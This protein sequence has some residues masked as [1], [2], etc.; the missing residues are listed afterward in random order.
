M[1]LVPTIPV[2]VS[3]TSAF[4]RTAREIMSAAEIEALIDRLAR[5]PKAGDII[6]GTGGVR[7]FRW[8]RPG[9]GKRG[10]V[11]VI[12]YYHDDTMPL[13]LL[14]AYAK[15]AVADI[16]A[17]QKRRIS[18]LVNDYARAQKERRSRR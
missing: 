16:T 5:D 17:D 3:E 12:Y 2:T 13:L 6:P 14:V 7:K 8:R 9:L 11:R 15:S 10:G 4:Q 1:V 18:A